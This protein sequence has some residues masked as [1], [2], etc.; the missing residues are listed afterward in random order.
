MLA[1]RLQLLITATEHQPLTVSLSMKTEATGINTT[2]VQTAHA[3]LKAAITKSSLEECLRQRQ[4][5]YGL[6]L[7]SKESYYGT[8][9]NNVIRRS[10][11]NTD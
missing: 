5:P 2:S 9:W 3:D 10:N 11:G 4:M 1:M 6:F 8:V 7:G